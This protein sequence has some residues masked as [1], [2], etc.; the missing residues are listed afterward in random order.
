MNNRLISESWSRILLQ[1][2]VQRFHATYGSDK[3]KT[4]QRN[5]HA[6]IGVQ[7]HICC[8]LEF[9]CF[10][11]ENERD[12][13]L[14]LVYNS[15]QQCVFV[16][17]FVSTAGSGEQPIAGDYEHVPCRAR[18]IVIKKRILKSICNY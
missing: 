15:S 4:A 13:L 14:F 6:R 8:Y 1:A 16:F 17:V 18:F 12:L 5:K 3:K 10:H 2:R 7:V 9:F 11:N